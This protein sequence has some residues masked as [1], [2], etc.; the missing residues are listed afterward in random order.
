MEASAGDRS[1][2]NAE[3]TCAK[4]YPVAD[5]AWDVVVEG[6]AADEDRITE[7]KHADVLGGIVAVLQMVLWS[8]QWD[9][10]QLKSQYL[11]RRIEGAISKAKYMS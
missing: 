4:E 7:D 5:A 3:L 10:W 9:F 11:P 8:P 2:M 1:L 6:D